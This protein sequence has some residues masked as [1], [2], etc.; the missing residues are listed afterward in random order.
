MH[1]LN[2]T[3]AHMSAPVSARRKSLS[4]QLA[5]EAK[6]IPNDGYQGILPCQEAEGGLYPNVDLSIWLRSCI[7]EC[8]TPVSGRVRG[9][10]P[11]WLAGSF[12]QNGPGKFYFGSQVAQ[13]LFDGSALVQKYYIDRGQ[14]SYSC[15]FL[16][17]NHFKK[18][19]AAQNI[20]TNEFATNG[21]NNVVDK[22]F[23]SRFSFIFDL[24]TMMSDN[25]FISVYPLGE[26]YYCFYE[27]PFITKVDPETLDTQRTINLNERLGVLSNGSHPHYDDYGNM[28]S[29]GMKVGF[30]GPEYIIT[31]I[32]VEDLEKNP[33]LSVEKQQQQQQ[34]LSYKEQVATKFDKASILAKVNSRWAM[35]PGY[36]HSFG[37]TDNYYILIEQPLT[38]NVP[39]LVSGT[40]QRKPMIESMRWHDDH[41]TIFHVINKITGDKTKITYKAKG[42]FFLHVIN[43]YE[44]EGHIVI[45]ICCYA[46][47][48][49][50]YCMYLDSLK[51]AQSDPKFAELFRGRPERFVLPL[52]VSSKDKGDRNLVSLPYTNAQ[53][54]LSKKNTV[55]VQSAKIC[56]VGCET[57]TIYYEKYNG[58]KYRYF[59]AITSDV[60][61]PVSAGKIYKVDTKTG[62]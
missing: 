25:T 26:D 11:L 5:E 9:Q 27:S 43:A 35:D 58:K 32:P 13:H 29:I 2:P 23:K 20:V 8:E 10:I 39:S 14:V 34:Y 24:T 54:F 36:M 52:N 37:L 17:T 51:T 53:A 1:H 28:I 45:D 15:K 38:V 33:T 62:K 50:L 46:R 3:A 18:N 42:F 48:D 41:S 47:P 60:D 40:I 59:Y 44:D 6:T 56:D 61:D 22:T 31:K 55:R 30:R 7:K 16:R 57:P 4:I 49:M 19:L 21:T 12:L